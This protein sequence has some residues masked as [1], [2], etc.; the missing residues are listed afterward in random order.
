MA[1]RCSVTDVGR[2]SPVQEAPTC[3]TESSNAHMA[4]VVRDSAATGPG[5]RG[6]A[7]TAYQMNAPLATAI[8]A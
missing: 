1:Q 6:R 7:S 8:T 5:A 3:P 2:N 4:S